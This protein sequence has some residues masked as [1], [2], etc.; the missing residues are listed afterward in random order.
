[1]LHVT[2]NDMAIV[3]GKRS[4]LQLLWMLE[5]LAQIKNE[6]SSID[7]EA[8]FERALKALCETNFA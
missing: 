5:K 8:R 6:I 3:H 4:A 7:L 2:Y 1:M